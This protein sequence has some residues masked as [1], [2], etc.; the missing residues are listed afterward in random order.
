MWAMNM[1]DLEP[2]INNYLNLVGDTINRIGR[3]NIA[4]FVRLMLD[5]YGAGGTIFVCGNGGSGATAAHFCGDFLKGVSCGLDKRF[6]VICLAD[7]IPTLMAVAN[8]ISYED[9]FVE[10]LK[11]FI[12]KGDLVI[13]ISGS[14]NSRN[15]IKAIEYAN[16]CEAKTVALCG[17]SGG[18]LKE[19]SSLSIHAEINDMEVSEDVH[20]IVLHCVKRVVG[21]I[22]KPRAMQPAK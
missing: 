20:L 12:K 22:L 18:K 14:G 1:N 16:S 9:I 5:T 17:F 4:K 2:G 7:N 8:D 6:K 10:P 13:G 19:I 11:N 3:E 21:D 15:V